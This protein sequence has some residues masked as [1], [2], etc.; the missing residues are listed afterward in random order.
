[1]SAGVDG[2]GPATARPHLLAARSVVFGTCNL[3]LLGVPAGWRL[4]DGTFPP[5]VDRWRVREGVS[6]ATAG[7]GHWWL[8]AR[9]GTGGGGRAALRAELFLSVAPAGPASAGAGPGRGYGLRRVDDA[10]SL[11]LAGHAA[12]WAAGAVRRGFPGRWRPARA[13]VLECTETRRRLELRL[14][15][16]P[17]GDEADLD[18][19]WQALLAQWRCH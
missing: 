3:V 10:G 16:T 8:A 11:E 12:W 9:S 18:A 4:A 1:M 15:A 13:L 2:D 17:V 14:E 7:R 5:E 19:A 6:W